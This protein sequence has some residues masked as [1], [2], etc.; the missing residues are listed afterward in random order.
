VT[1]LGILHDYEWFH[2]DRATKNQLVE[3]IWS[4]QGPRGNDTL[5]ASALRRI[6]EECRLLEPAVKNITKSSNPCFTIHIYL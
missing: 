1:R 6:S 3:S 2:V 4:L 5:C